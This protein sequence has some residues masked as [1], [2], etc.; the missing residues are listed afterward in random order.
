M[1]RFALVAA[2]TVV[3]GF[4]SVM[5]YGNQPGARPLDALGYG[6]LAL[7]VLGLAGPREWPGFGLAV[8]AVP[9]AVLFVLGYAYALWPAPALIAVFATISAG[10]RALGWAGTGFLVAVPTGAVLLDRTLDNLTG[11]LLWALIAVVVGQLAEVSGARRAHAREVERRMVEAERTREE[12]ARG[13]ARE[14]RLKVARELHDVTSHTV[15]LI[16]LHAAVAAEAIDR[17]GGPE[18]AR[19]ALSVIRTASREALAEMK[20]ILGVLREDGPEGK[21]PMPGA[22]QL[23][24]LVA[25][26]GLPVEFEVAGERRALAPAVD[27]TAYRVVQEALT[28]TMRHAGASTARV[29]LSF[30]TGGVTIQVDDDGRGGGTLPPGA[31][32]GVHGRPGDGERRG[33]GGEVTGGEC[34]PIGDDLIG[35]VT[36]GGYGL[37]G[38]A[39]R[40]AAVGGRL[41]VGDRPEG[42][43]Q[44]AVWLPA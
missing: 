35:D 41:V 11:L 17:S 12:M 22:G 13:R 36:R 31:S 27:L 30:E 15:S 32:S 44:V 38:M 21:R 16:A 33:T 14:E 28:N 39:E 20:G 37:A 40:V 25:S 29:R 34:R 2:M 3:V 9:A 24:E 6:L 42:G 19:E 10:R 23:E 1:S 18:A 26:A 43:F 7:T 8:C 5:A 4:S